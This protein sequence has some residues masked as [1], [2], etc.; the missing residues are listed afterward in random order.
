MRGSQGLIIIAF[1]SVLFTGFT[2]LVIAVTGQAGITAHCGWM[3]GAAGSVP[4]IDSRP[5]FIHAR[6]GVGKVE[7]GRY[8]NI[9]GVTI[10]A[11]S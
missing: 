9:H 10:I 3:T 4:M 7:A 2:A 11:C 6:F 5:F 8:P 1:P